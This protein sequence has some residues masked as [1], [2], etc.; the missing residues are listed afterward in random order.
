MRRRLDVYERADR[1][2]ASTTTGSRGLLATVAGEGA[3]D[4]GPA[5]TSGKA[6]EGV[7]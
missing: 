7:R 6:A 3:V 4:D 5:T 2:A 1:A